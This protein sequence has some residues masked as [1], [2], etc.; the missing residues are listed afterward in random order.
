M[1]LTFQQTRPGL[2]TDSG[3][4]PGESDAPKVSLRSRLRIGA[5]SY[6]QQSIR[7]TSDNAS[8]YSKEG[9]IF[10]F[11]EESSKATRGYGEGKDW[12]SVCLYPTTHA[13][14]DVPRRVRE[15]SNGDHKLTSRKNRFSGNKSAVCKDF[16]FLLSDFFYF[17]IHIY[18]E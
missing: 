3:T 16:S 8:S 4:I 5:I 11:H 2:F 15:S 1:S 13:P 6:P 18:Q 17:F 12:Q 14:N 9:G 10:N 7:Q